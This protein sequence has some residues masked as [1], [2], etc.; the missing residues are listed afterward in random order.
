MY[1]A[2]RSSGSW[3]PAPVVP[4]DHAQLS[5]P[6]GSCRSHQQGS[7]DGGD[8]QDYREGRPDLGAKE[9]DLHGVR[10]LDNEDHQHDQRQDAD[11]QGGTGA[12][13]Q[14]ARDW[15]LSWRRRTEPLADG[16]GSV[17]AAPA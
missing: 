4:H 14:G 13:D 16:G 5:D 15:C 10:V 6:G 7:C 9:A 2:R 1:T 17:P 11:D 3:W 8:Q 12:A